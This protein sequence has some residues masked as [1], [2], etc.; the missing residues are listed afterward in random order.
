MSTV[1]APTSNLLTVTATPARQTYLIDGI[2]RTTCRGYIYLYTCWISMLFC[3]AYAVALIAFGNTIPISFVALSVLHCGIVSAH[4]AICVEYHMADIYF[5]NYIKEHMHDYELR[6]QKYDWILAYAMNAI[7]CIL[8][9]TML[10]LRESNLHGL[11][12]ILYTTSAAK[13]ALL[14]VFAISLKIPVSNQWN[15]FIIVGVI[16][17]VTDAATVSALVAYYNYGYIH[18]TGILALFVVT[19][20][21]AI[22]G[23]S[24]YVAGQI[25]NPNQSPHFDT[26][27]VMHVGIVAAIL[28]SY[29]SI[30]LFIFDK[31]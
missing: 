6:I 7:S 4:C 3:A 20:I 11:N 24:T 1:S 18:S 9:N 26:H 17:S 29:V 15:I 22:V 27:D 5:K 25:L 23:T 21:L 16:L 12:Y 31:I 19:V 10:I 8:Y 13:V 30:G 2:S 14:L 28:T